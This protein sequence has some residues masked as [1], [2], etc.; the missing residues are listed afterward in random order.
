MFFIY[1]V[2]L[3]EDSWHDII[4]LLLLSSEIKQGC[5]VVMKKA[6]IFASCLLSVTTYAAVPTEG[7]Y[8]GIFF[9]PTYAPKLNFTLTNPL[10]GIPVS[11]ELTYQSSFNVGGQVG[12]RY[13]KFR[14]EGEVISNQNNYKSLEIGSMNVSTHLNTLG[15]QLA[16]NTR[17]FA[18]L[19]NIYYEIYPNEMEVR[20]VPYVGVGGGYTNIKNSINMTYL[21]RIAYSRSSTVSAPIGQVI[22]GLN[23]LF[24]D[25]ASVGLD[26]RYLSTPNHQKLNQRISLETINIVGSWSFG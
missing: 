7:W 2:I 10:L 5:I 11:S 18:G 21:Q 25:R 23:Y 1:K 17:F 12:Y 8:G 9:G 20:L 15:L 22:A 6:V 24:T 16:G 19:L 14:Y 13:G 26:F 4:K 3:T